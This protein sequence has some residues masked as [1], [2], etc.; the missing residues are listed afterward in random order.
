MKILL[1]TTASRYSKARARRGGKARR[2]GGLD[3]HRRS[4]S[5]LRLRAA[6]SRDGHVD[7]PPHA[8]EDMK[9]AH[10]FLHERGIE[11]ETKIGTAT[12][13]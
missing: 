1:D 2:R 7:L 4:A 12:G 3:G 9:I 6:P 5:S 11:A 8:E 10:D 13:G